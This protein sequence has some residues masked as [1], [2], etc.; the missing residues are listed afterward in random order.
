MGSPLPQQK[1]G[2]KE[3]KKKQPNKQTQTFGEK[4]LPNNNKKKT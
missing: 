1:K 2:R 4:S 3:R